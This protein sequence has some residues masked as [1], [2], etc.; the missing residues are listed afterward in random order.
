MNWYDTIVYCNLRS[1]AEN[2]TPVYKLG[3]ETDPTN[4]S[5][6]VGDAGTK[7]CG[8]SSSDTAWDGITADFSAD[9]YR[10]PTDTACRRRPNGST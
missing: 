4:W 9:G 7:F 6:I 5:G 1:M 10:L 2:L 3:G 8:P